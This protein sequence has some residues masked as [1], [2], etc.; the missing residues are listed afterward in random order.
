ML[1]K[2]EVKQKRK[3]V[4]MK[5]LITVTISALALQGCASSIEAFYNRPVVEDSTRGVTTT[6]SMSAD[7]RTVIVVTE[8]DNI[9]KFCAEAPPD[10]AKEISTELSSKLE[11]EVKQQKADLEAKG[12]GELK[13]KL[14]TKV[15]VL[16]ERTAELD[17]FRAGLYALC[18]YHLNGAMSADQVDENFKELVKIF[19]E[20]G[21]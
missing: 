10:A 8:G 6:V 7:R 14:D 19:S 5:R 11:A 17:A 15:V 13:D 2:P 4:S 18:Q 21:N 16:S 3:E 12:K 1:I 9:G 20:P